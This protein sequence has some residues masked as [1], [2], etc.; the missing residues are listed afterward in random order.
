MVEYGVTPYIR[1]RGSECSSLRTCEKLNGLSSPYWY[2]EEL[3]AQDLLDPNRTQVFHLA[4][5]VFMSQTG[6]TIVP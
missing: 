5:E 6:A 3:F 1:C 2:S 4:G